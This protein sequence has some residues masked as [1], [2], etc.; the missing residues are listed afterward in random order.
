M[1]VTGV[2]AEPGKQITAGALNNP[3]LYERAAA[4]AAVSQLIYDFGRTSNLVASANLAEK[5]QNQ[6]EVATREQILLAVSQAFYE[7]LQSHAVVTV[8]EQTVNER[9]TVANQINELFKNKLKSELD[10]S[11]AN[12]NLAQAK[13]CYWM[14]RTVTIRRAP[15][16]Q[17]SWDFPACRITSWLRTR[18]RQ[19][20]RQPILTT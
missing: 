4:G 2:E 14:R 9:Q 16:F 15:T 13:C 19:C 5:A 17:W 8:A 18:L 11:F 3:I 6:D 12:V 7:A 1:N 20:S 10:L